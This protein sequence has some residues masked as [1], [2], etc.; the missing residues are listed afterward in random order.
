MVRTSHVAACWLLL[1]A[2]VLV[3]SG[4]CGLY[5]VSTAVGGVPEVLPPGMIKFADPTV[6]DLVEALTAA[7]P[8]AHEVVPSEFHEK[9]KEDMESRI[10]HGR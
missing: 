5:V 4:S 7:I 3:S 1:A 9:V 2:F 10:P 8:I 6:G